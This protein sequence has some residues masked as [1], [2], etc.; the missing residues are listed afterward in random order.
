MVDDGRAHCDDTSVELP[1]KI[2]KNRTKTYHKPYARVALVRL[3]VKRSGAFKRFRQ[4]TSSFTIII[5]IILD[6]TRN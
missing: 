5:I 1:S 2:Q 3:F 4:R 6:D